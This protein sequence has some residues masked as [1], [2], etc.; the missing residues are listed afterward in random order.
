LV[1]RIRRHAPVQAL[2]AC[3]VTAGLAQAR[4]G[5]SLSSDEASSVWFTRLPLSTL[6]TSLCDPHPSGYYA[7]LKFW[8]AGG[9]DEFW[10]R[11][12]SLLAAVL[13]VAFTYRLGRAVG[14]RRCAQ[15]AVWLIALHP[16]QSWYAGEV[17]MYAL[18]QSLSLLMVWLGWRLISGPVRP[19]RDVALYGLTALVALGI[20]YSSL[21][22]FGLLQ[23][24]W[25]ARNRPD[26]RRWL[27]LQAGVVLSAIFLWLNPSQLRALRHGYQAIFVAVQAARLGLDLTPPE[28]ARLLISVTLCLLLISLTLAWL[29]PRHGRGQFDRPLIRLI[30]LGGWLALLLLAALPR[31]LTVKRQVI[32]LLPYLA[33]LTGYVATRFPRPM[34]PLVAGLG[35]AI[36][37]LVLPGHQREPWRAVVGDLAQT[38]TDSGL[39]LWVDDLAVPAVDYYLRVA[40]ADGQQIR[41]TPLFG[42]RLP[43][44]PELR[45]EPGESLWIVTAESDYR[46]LVNLLPAAFYARYQLLETRPN[47]GIGLYLFQQ[48]A[49]LGRVWTRN[50]TSDRRPSWGLEL[51]SPLDT[52]Q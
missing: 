51:P 44:L 42:G 17:R 37:V 25:V 32:V 45:P 43:E 38:K 35:L 49:Q 3:L 6:L 41:W 12:I 9:E 52:C 20:D 26:P 34:G 23:L 24:Y 19:R 10:L 40:G 27:G 2:I 5:R 29:W 30:V 1:G 7:L 16:L 31:L 18:A 8:R 36:T 33:L 4:L 11:L 14:G 50:L 15:F 47:V 39:V 46:Q 28:A 22:A 13:A 48:R 21:L